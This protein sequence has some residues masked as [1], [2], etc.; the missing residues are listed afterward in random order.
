MKK[1]IVFL[2]VIQMIVMS[3]Y[4]LLFVSSYAVTSLS[5][6]TASISLIFS[7]TE[8]YEFFLDLAENHDLTV[9]REVFIDSTNLII[10]T[11]D[12]TL[13]GRIELIKGRWPAIG[14]NEFVSVSHT[15]ESS[16]VGVI[17]NIT[18]DFNLSL[19]HIKNTTNVSLDGI[20]LINSSNLD[21]VESFVGVLDQNIY[22][23][24][25]FSVNNHGNIFARM[26]E[27]QFIELIVMSLLLFVCVVAAFVNYAVTQLK[28]G[29]VLLVHGHRKIYVLKKATVDLFKLLI[30]AFV[31]SY[32]L[33][34]IYTYVSGY[35]VFLGL[36]SLFFVLIFLGLSFFYLFVFQSFMSIYLLSVKSNRIL[37]G[38]KPY[39]MLQVANYI[40]KMTFSIAILV[41]SSLAISNFIELNHRLDA[42]SAWD[43][44]QNT[45]MTRVFSVGQSTDLS[46]DLEVMT[47]QL[48]L[49]ESL[50]REHNAFIM[51]SSNVYFLDQGLMPYADMHLAPLMELSPNG[52]SITI[53]PNFLD[54]NPIKAVNGIDIHDQIN[55]NPDVLN[56]L[57]PERLA[58]H[59]D[60]ILRLYLE[61]FHFSKVEIDNIYNRDL[62]LELN[63]T[64]KDDLSIHIIYIEDGQYYFSFN[65]RVRVE[66]ENRI[67]DPIAILYTG[68]V[69]PSRL[70]QT[71]GGYF[72]FQTNA[73]NAHNDI[74]PLLIEHNLSHVIRS[75]ES[76]FDQND[77]VITQLQEQVITALILIVILTLSS[78]A[79]IYGLM[80]QYFEKNKKLIFVK[81]I[82]GYPFIQRHL[83]FLLLV[84]VY[85]IGVVI[86]LIFLLGYNVFIPGL[87]LLGTDLAFIFLIDKKLTSDSFSKIT[88]GGY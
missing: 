3:M 31:I 64:K 2:I 59:E 33:T 14:E 57:V 39:V 44:A 67:L 87:L 10:Y 4:G 81:S 35:T 40:A 7:D 23:A 78:V 49:Y 20:Y 71:M 54:L 85:H 21:V 65:N 12:L 13:D 83:S 69:H 53:S 36:I 73:I 30:A 17:R 58:V 22:R 46:I 70:S 24:E 74:L 63:N 15:E 43:L 66:A 62:G 6:N 11:S 50:S 79:I 55:W 52:Y 42:F 61:E 88:K 37:K 41:F 72:F 5:A 77:Q 27:M 38:E 51:D 82:F 1:V 84:I 9:T 80:S 28:A 45:H 86:T 16:Q 26:T 47:N 56:I 75:T 19:S 76:V 60:E 34:V 48:S 25:L 8:E 18:P 68:S 32:I 29:S